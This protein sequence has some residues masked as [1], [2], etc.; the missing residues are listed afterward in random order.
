VLYAFGFERV[1]V[2][3]GDVFFVDPNPG[4]GQEGAESGVRLEVRLVDRPE[5]RGSIYSVQPIEIGRA[6]WRADFFETVEGEPRSHDRT[7]HHPRVRG[8]E[9][10]RRAW[11]DDLAA[12]P[13]EWL[14]RKLAD[15]DALVAE[16]DIDA[17][18]V[19]PDDARQLR[20][21]VPEILDVVRRLLERVRAGELAKPPADY[22]HSDEPVLARSG[23]L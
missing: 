20:D 14:G 17:S 1:G 15:L 11:D 9:P 21:A 12:N 10:G 6:I 5:L 16:A 22:R 7:H 18:D 13:I 4:P 23:W 19:D 8:W 2:V 3:V